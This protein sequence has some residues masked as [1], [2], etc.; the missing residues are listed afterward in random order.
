MYSIEM[1][2]SIATN[3]YQMG[4]K[5]KEVILQSAIGLHSSSH[6]LRRQQIVQQSILGGIFILIAFVPFLHHRIFMC[7]WIIDKNQNK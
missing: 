3:K 2:V 6:L 7:D 1:L 5:E 4:L